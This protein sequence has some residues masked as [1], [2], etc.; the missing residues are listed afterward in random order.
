VIFILEEKERRREPR[1]GRKEK[2]KL[3]DQKKKDMIEEATEQLQAP[4]ERLLR[5]TERKGIKL[6]GALD[7]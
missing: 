4:V 5:C 1:G 7:P 6:Q 3:K 2:V